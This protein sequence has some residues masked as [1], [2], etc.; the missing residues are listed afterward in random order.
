MFC[1]RSAHFQ[2]FSVLK[3]LSCFHAYLW[4]IPAV[5]CKSPSNPHQTKTG[6]SGWREIEKEQQQAPGGYW[7]TSCSLPICFKR[8]SLWSLTLHVRLYKAIILLLLCSVILYHRYFHSSLLIANV[9]CEEENALPIKQHR[10]LTL[11]VFVNKSSMSSEYI[12]DNTEH[13]NWSD[14]LWTR[15][16]TVPQSCHKDNIL[17]SYVIT[18]SKLQESVFSNTDVHATASDSH[19]AVGVLLTTEGPWI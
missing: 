14:M 6:N 17:V 16:A 10:M 7:S 3:W 18:F 9:T 13:K 8:R 11:K 12:I 15:S 2:A 4:K 1:S 19:T 5:S